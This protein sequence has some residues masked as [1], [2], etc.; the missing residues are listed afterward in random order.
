MH[1]SALQG[2]E[3]CSKQALKLSPLIGL[4]GT[5]NVS[6][7]TVGLLDLRVQL[8]VLGIIRRQPRVGFPTLRHR[9]DPRAVPAQAFDVPPEKTNQRSTPLVDSLEQ[10]LILVVIHLILES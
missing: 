3:E 2:S 5:Q 10:I 9:K 1:P 6:A 8:S 7:D 4:L